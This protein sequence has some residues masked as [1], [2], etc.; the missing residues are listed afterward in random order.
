MTGVLFCA[1]VFLL[2]FAAVALLEARKPGLLSRR[3]EHL[4]CCGFRDPACNRGRAAP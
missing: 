4:R 1:I 3:G 2:V